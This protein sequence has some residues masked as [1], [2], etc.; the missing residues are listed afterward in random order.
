M[1]EPLE[2]DSSFRSRRLRRWLWRR[3][4]SDKPLRGNRATRALE[5][6]AIIVAATAIYLLVIELG[7]RLLIHAPLFE[8]RDFRHERAARTINQ[9]VQYD[10]V[11]GWRLKSGIKSQGFNTL[12]YGFRSNG[13]PDVE[14][15]QGGVL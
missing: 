4:R 5:S 2:V 1:T 15:R 7:V 12:Q 3:P 13:G 9:A 11:L 8:T 6:V 10:S 14:V